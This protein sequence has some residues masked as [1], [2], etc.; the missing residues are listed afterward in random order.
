MHGGKGSGAPIGNRNAWKYGHYSTRDK[1]ARWW[2][3]MLMNWGDHIYPNAGEDAP[4]CP[5]VPKHHLRPFTDR[6][7]RAMKKILKALGLVDVVEAVERYHT[8]PT[9]HH[10]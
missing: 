4:R 2:F 5:S 6:E 7:W 10:R 1:M 9:A 3:Q 8:V